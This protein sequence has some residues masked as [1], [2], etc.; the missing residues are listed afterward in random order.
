[1]HLN[2]VILVGLI[3]TFLMAAFP[4]WTVRRIINHSTGAYSPPTSY[5]WSFIFA[6]PTEYSQY[7]SR[8]TQTS[9]IDLTR[10][11]LQLVVI[12]LAVGVWVVASPAM[13]ARL[14]AMKEEVVRYEAA[15][16][17]EG[18]TLTLARWPFRVAAGVTAACVL[19]LVSVGVM[20]NI[21]EKGS[22]R[23]KPTPSKKTAVKPA[24]VGQPATPA[25]DAWA[26]FELI[27]QPAPT[28]P[29]NRTTELELKEAR[30]RMLVEAYRRGLLDSPDMME[31]R[32]EA[33]ALLEGVRRRYPQHAA[34]T[35]R[36][37]A[38][39]VIDQYERRARD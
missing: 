23:I 14:A 5:G 16:V 36:E 27:A 15:R 9:S 19:A 2:R 30:A 29:H 28:A 25:A 32:K 34:M 11:L 7:R 37:L 10:L 12:W 13:K 22:R 24:P 26:Q 18:T 17:R 4:P 1:M 21:N 38:A 8:I 3:L 6:P 31:K 39:F 20:L 35:D 33:I